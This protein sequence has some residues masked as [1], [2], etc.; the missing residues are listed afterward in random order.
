MALS[1]TSHFDADHLSG[2]QKAELHC[3]AGKNKVALIQCFHSVP[4]GSAEWV[5]LLDPL[6]NLLSKTV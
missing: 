4:K 2:T 3:T 1:A 6:D 5:L